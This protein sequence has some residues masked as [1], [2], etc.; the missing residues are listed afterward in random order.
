LK[1]GAGGFGDY[2]ADDGGMGGWGVGR[3]NPM[4]RRT[5]SCEL[6]RFE[7]RGARGSAGQCSDLEEIGELMLSG[8]GEIWNELRT[9]VYFVVAYKYRKLVNTLVMLWL[10]C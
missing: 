4:R 7:R 10:M 8:P 3:K 5:S 6:A 1:N 2:R 9:P